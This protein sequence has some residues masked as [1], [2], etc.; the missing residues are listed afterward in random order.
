M[1]LD[2]G[3]NSCYFATDKTGQRTNGGCRCF[4]KANVKNRSLVSCAVEL[5]PKYLQAQ[6][7]IIVLKAAIKDVIHSDEH[8]YNKPSYINRLQRALD[9][10]EGRE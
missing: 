7:D 5:L 10:V 8:R 1:Q 6:E 2:C 3:D 4:D 9:V